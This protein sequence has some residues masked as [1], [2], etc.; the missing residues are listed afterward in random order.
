MERGATRDVLREQGGASAT[1]IIQEIKRAAR[2]SIRFVEEPNKIIVRMEPE[3]V[4]GLLERLGIPLQSGVLDR[5]ITRIKRTLTDQGDFHPDAVLDIVPYPPENEMHVSFEASRKVHWNAGSG[6]DPVD[7]GAPESDLLSALQG[8]DILRGSFNPTT[9]EYDLV[10]DGVLDQMVEEP[11]S[12]TF[13][14]RAQVETVRAPVHYTVK[15]YPSSKGPMSHISWRLLSYRPETSVS[16]MDFF[17]TPGQQ[18]VQRVADDV[19]AVLSH[20]LKAAVSPA[21][22]GEDLLSESEAHAWAAHFVNEGEP[23]AEIAGVPILVKYMAKQVP[24]L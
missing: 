1:P 5:F 17:K 21:R 14:W 22:S 11:Y 12:L 18:S 19:T 7:L 23:A 4:A 6:G 24:P 2:Q 15:L 13:E 20:V 9:G 16:A 10:P 3:Q 8:M